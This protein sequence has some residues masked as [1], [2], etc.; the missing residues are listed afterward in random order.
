M[1]ILY[2]SFNGSLLP[3]SAYLKMTAMYR[4]VLGYWERPEIPY[5]YVWDGMIFLS[6]VHLLH[7]LE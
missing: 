4:R 5:A 6:Q 7:V 2:I 3:P 1:V